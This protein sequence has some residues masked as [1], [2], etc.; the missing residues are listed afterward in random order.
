M[1]YLELILGPMFSGKS[2]R[3]IQ[4]IR[5][6]RILNYSILVIK[7]EIDVR[8]TGSESPQ[9]VTHDKVATDCITCK[10]LSEITN[11]DSYQ[12]IIV[13]EGQ[14]F[15]DIFEKVV[16]WCK[17]KKVYVAGLNGDANQNLFGNLYK[18][19]AHADEITFLKAL[20]KICNDGTPAIFTKK[21]GN[22][23]QVVEVGGEELYEAV[24]RKHR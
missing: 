1:A 13:E 16:E 4:T 2:S 18:L 8:Y 15:S 14:F 22:N 5:K 19:V 11:I 23:D 24:C 17:T 10:S 21:N 7:P 6:Y 3:L 9:I 12:V 20:C